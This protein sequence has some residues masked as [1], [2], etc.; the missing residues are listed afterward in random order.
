MEHDKPPAIHLPEDENAPA[1]EYV[2]YQYGATAQDPSF[3]LAETNPKGF[4]AITPEMLAAADQKAGLT[5]VPEKVPV[6]AKLK[7]Y[8]SKMFSNNVEL[9]CQTYRKSKR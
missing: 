8:F 6:G 4:Q 2:D 9:D 1:F 7:Q 5:V 3:Y